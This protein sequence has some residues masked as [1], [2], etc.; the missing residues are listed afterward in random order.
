MQEMQI[1]PSVDV[2]LEDSMRGT[3]EVGFTG[4]QSQRGLAKET[5]GGEMSCDLRIREDPLMLPW[6]NFYGGSMM[7]P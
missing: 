4:P 7:V 6:W 1:F 3:L 5:V 2:S